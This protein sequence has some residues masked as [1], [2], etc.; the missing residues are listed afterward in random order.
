MREKLEKRI[1][2]SAKKELADIVITNAKIVNV[3]TGEIMK[4]DVAI[5]DDK[6]AGIGSY[7]GQRVI[8]AEGKYLV[9]GLID[10]HVHIESSMLTPQEFAKV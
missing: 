10:A 2:V 8:D 3:F 7:K 5:A 9:P 1:R 4:G 6:I